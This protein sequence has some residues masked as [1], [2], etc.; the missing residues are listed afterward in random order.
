M[1]TRRGVA[2]A[3]HIRLAEGANEHVSEEQEA[4][5][6]WGLAFIILTTVVK[7]E[8]VRSHPLL[9]EAPQT[10]LRASVSL[11]VSL[12]PQSC[13]SHKGNQSPLSCRLQVGTH[14][15]ASSFD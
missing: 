14:L 15:Q 10:E 13:L 3:E 6:V 1:S 12:G 11:S 9:V 7:C 4:C 5:R 8:N 2:R